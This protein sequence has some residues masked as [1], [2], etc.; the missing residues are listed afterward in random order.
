[1]EYI[2]GKLN[3]LADAFSRLP[4]FEDGGFVPS[5]K[6]SL[7]APANTSM[8]LLDEAFRNKRWTRDEDI[9]YDDSFIYDDVFSNVDDRELFECLLWY[10][11]DPSLFNYVNLP[12]T[13]ENPLKVPWLRE[14]Q[15][16]DAGLLQQL[17]TDP[18]HYQLRTMNGVEL[19][20][21]RNEHE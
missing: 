15:Q 9:I 6:E 1:M 5:S 16:Q 18:A 13:S 12:A 3:V 20:K 10:P 21:Y 11:E 7:P 4:K 14:C 17:T 19:I 8:H 2:E